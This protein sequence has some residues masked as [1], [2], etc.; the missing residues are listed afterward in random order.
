MLFTNTE[1][2][3][4]INRLRNETSKL[5]LSAV[6]IFDDDRFIGGGG[7]RYFSG[8]RNSTVPLT[9]SAFVVLTTSEAEPV[10]C[11]APGFKE[12][13]INLARRESWCK[14]VRGTTFMMWQADYAK[15]VGESLKSAGIVVGK[16]GIDSYRI[17][18]KETLGAL[19]KILPEVNFVDVTGL[20]EKIRSVK[21][22]AE[23]GLIEKATSLSD[24][25]IIKFM[26]SVR[27]GRYQYQAVS[28]AEHAVR[29]RGAEEA[30]MPMSAGLP[31]LWGMYRDEIKFRQGD[32]VAAEFNAR[33]KGYYG[34]VCRTSVIG[35]SSEAQRDIYSTTF[36]AATTMTKA[37]KP[38]VRANELFKMGMDIVAKRGYS[39]SGI[40]FGHGLGLTIA[41]HF[42]IVEG[43]DTLLE[44]GNYI[45]IHPSIVEHKEGSCAILGDPVLITKSGAK[46]FSKAKYQIEVS[47]W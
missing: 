47:K 34:Q 39:F 41:E 21:S 7:V 35:R 15:D 30:S 42:D 27:A 23:I 29:I 11:I 26:R 4:R 14:N 5:G 44:S 43:N 33:V 19:Q 2:F 45:M 8:Y 9:P 28:E 24:L 6:V 36:E 31:W 46:V 13:Q 3:D 37:A 12:C 10:L 18:G 20:T 22:K 1:Y 38:G 32:M 40:R 25:G 16:V 17:I